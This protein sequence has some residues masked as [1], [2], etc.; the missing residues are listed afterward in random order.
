[1]LPN[2]YANFTSTAGHVVC[3]RC[4][5]SFPEGEEFHFLHDATGEGPGKRVCTQCR[6]YYITKTEKAGQSTRKYIKCYIFA[7]FSS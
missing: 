3:Q 4:K 6:Q 2:N 5:V 1:M 7:V